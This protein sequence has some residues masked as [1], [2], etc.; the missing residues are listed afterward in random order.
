MHNCHLIIAWCVNLKES[1]KKEEIDEL[2]GLLHD[3]RVG[4]FYQNTNKKI[5]NIYL[6]MWD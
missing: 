3:R 1:F 6:Q 2:L 4:E 5:L